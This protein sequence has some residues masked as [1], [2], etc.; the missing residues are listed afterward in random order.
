MDT[1]ILFNPTSKKATTANR[2]VII[3]AVQVMIW[4]PVTPIFLP[5]KPEAIDPN[6]GKIIIARY[7]I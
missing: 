2:V 1:G 5:K 7:I 6:N 4:D 3:T